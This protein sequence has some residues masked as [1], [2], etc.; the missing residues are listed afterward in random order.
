MDNQYIIWGKAPGGEMEILLVSD[1][2]GLF[3]YDAMVEVCHILHH[4][5]GCTELRGERLTPLGDGS[6]LA[7]MFKAAVA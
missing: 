2:A 4:Q 7:S 3:G 6:E 1:A 5:H